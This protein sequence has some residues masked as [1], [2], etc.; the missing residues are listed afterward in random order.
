VAWTTWLPAEQVLVFQQVGLVGENLLDP[1]RPLLVP[2]TRQAEGLVPGRKL[3]RAGAGVLRQRDSEH[4]D[5]N[6]VDVVFCLRLGEAERVDLHA[7]A[8][9]AVLRVGDAV[10]LAGDLVPKLAEGPHLAHLGDEPH[11]GVDEERDAADDFAECLGR[12]FAG[13]LHGIENGDGCGERVG[14][15]LHWRRPC[16]LQMVGADVH[17]VPLRHLLCREQDGVLGEAERRRRR[18][19]VGAARQVF[20]D[21][22]VLNG[23]RQL[24]AGCARLVGDGNIKRQKPSCRRIDRHRGIHLVERNAVEQGQHVSEVRDWNAYF[25]D[26]ASGKFVVRVVARL[27]R[28]IEGDREARLPLSQVFLIECVRL[29][30][31]RVSGIGPEQPRLVAH[32]FIRHRKG[33]LR[34]GSMTLEMT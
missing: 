17:R 11:A 26:F 9:H 31:G 32:D 14:E 15:L 4:L 12:D 10:A 3:N 16:F 24:G 20:L 2:R 27:G 28:K 18:E 30:C 6:A 1:Q 22:V 34:L 25:T 33:P 7:I 13:C 29:G 23:A 21:D 19:H 5:Q 8:E